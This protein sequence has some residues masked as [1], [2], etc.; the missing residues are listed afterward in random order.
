MKGAGRSFRL[1]WSLIVFG[2]VMSLGFVSA[3]DALAAGSVKV[4]PTKGIAG[5]TVQFTGDLPPKKARKI[6]L[7][8]KSGSKWVKVKT[9]K[10]TKA[11]KFTIETKVRSGSTTY[12][13]YAPAAKIGGKKVKAAATSAKKVTTQA[14]SGTL[15][16]PTSA[17][18]GEQFEA[19]ATFKPAR[20]GRAVELQ[21]KSGSKWVKVATGK[22]DSNGKVSFTIAAGKTGKFTYRAVTK[23]AKGAKAK[24]KATKSKTIK[25]TN[26]TTSTTVIGWG[27]NGYGQADVPTELEGVK[28]VA[29]QGSHN[30]ALKTDGTVVAWGWNHDGQA[31][32]PTGLKNVQS[33]AAGN[34]HSLALKT[35]GTVVGWGWNKYGQAD[36]PT[37]LKNVTA[38]AAG[39]GYSL[40]LQSDGTVV[41][42]GWNNFGQADVPTGLKNVTAIA[43]G[44]G[45]SLALQ[46][47]GTVV[48]WGRNSYGETNVPSGLENVTA[49]A[50]GDAHSLAIVK[51]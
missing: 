14:Q 37:G 51:G 9:A 12:R 26:E 33:I 19:T 2:L 49:I 44:G 41:A 18:K 13:V 48:A 42:W 29:T 17:Y 35:D 39:G 38:I 45:H 16:L 5:E 1:L 28:A 30:L 34:L 27:S 15:K 31:D 25:I 50:A 23:A 40:A 8:R 36:V 7:Q 46:S 32:V 20:K 4:S 22:Q 24:A 21:S 47:D 11:G 3:P 10:T 43:A 6:V